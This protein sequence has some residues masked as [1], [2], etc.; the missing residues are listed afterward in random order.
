MRIMKIRRVLSTALS[1]LLLS[2]AIFVL[3]G[4]LGDYELREVAHHFRDLPAARLVAAA[5]LAGTCY[6]LRT[7]Y[8]ALAFRYLRRRLGY[9]RI[10]L[11]SFIGYALSHNLGLTVLTGGAVRYRFYSSNG[12]SAVQIAKI[13]AMNGVTFT[14]GF[15]AIAGAV[16]TLVP[17]PIPEMI[18]IPFQSFRAIGVAFLTVPLLYIVWCAWIRTPIRFRSWRVP[19]PSLGVALAQIAVAAADCAAA[20]GALY[21][22]VPA[23]PETGYLR[24]LGVISAASIVGL[25]SHIPGNLGVLEAVVLALM[26]PPLPAAG[27][28]GG[29][30]AFRGFY[31][32][33][34]LVVAILLFAA[35]EILEKTGLMRRLVTIEPE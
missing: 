6:L 32:L 33:V 31:Y 3:A 27:L 9:G 20:A 18:P 8:D 17:P 13:I 30:L 19:V 12:L 25:V 2:A 14:V 23:G 1:L 5:A 35:H 16:F 28:L 10:A 29:V 11:T 4:K 21:L 34:P 26:S 22:L 15:F 24:V 7:G